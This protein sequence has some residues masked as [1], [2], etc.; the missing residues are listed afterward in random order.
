[1]AGRIPQHFIDELIARADIVE[2]VGA[3][4]PL[5][6]GGREYKGLCPFHNENTPSFTVSPDKGFYHCFGCGAHGTALGFLMDHDHLGF[7]EAV[8][9][10]ASMVGMEV[11]RD[12]G[13][14]KLRG[15]DRVIELLRR[16]AEFYQRCLRD[17]TTAADY[18]KSRG[19]D[20]ATARDYGIG[21]AP[22]GWDTLAGEFG[23]DPDTETLLQAGG[24]VIRRD[25]GGYYDRFRDRV[26]FPIRDGRGRVVG[27]GGRVL[28]KGEPKYL[29]SPETVV[30]SKR[31]EL[32]GMYEVRR[33]LRDIP[34][35]IVVEG[36]MDVV[37][38][39]RNGV[40][41]AV[42]T[43]G[44][45]TT[46]EH[47]KR[48]FRMT[49]EVV[50]CFDGDRAGRQAAWRALEVALPEAR[51]GHQ[52]RFAFLPDGEDPDSLVKA[53]G[54]Q[55]LESELD[56]SLSLSEFLVEELS[57]GLDKASLDGRAQLAER[58]RPL[59]AKVPAGVYRELLIERLA[60]EV[61]LAGA[62]LNELMKP[63]KAAQQTT[64]T[65]QRRNRRPPQQLSLIAR[66]IRALLHRPAL[67]D[68]VDPANLADLTRP[69][70]EL[71]LEL[72]EMAQSDP[73]LTPAALLERM[74]PNT[75][76]RHLERLLGSEF[77]EHAELD[78]AAEFDGCIRQLRTEAVEMRI[79]ALRGRGA[80][81]LSETE[82][83]ELLV[84]LPA[85]IQTLR[86][87]AA[88]NEK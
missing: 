5:T 58:A 22:D 10:L 62:K 14:E 55:A 51:D 69:G 9:Q 88:S 72:L 29:N 37:A 13:D 77:I 57:N 45:A 24:L 54:S 39:A 65:T 34:R 35:L 74:R 76:F 8:E 73:Q 75:H 71:L 67:A 78:L 59:L 48:L 60:D 80:A 19:I 70:T 38:L 26:I 84:E 15:S 33:R 6:R 63:A 61:G 18:L 16:V 81:N 52:M 23:S 30:F 17:N 79:A 40:D 28:G 87:A 3:R 32:Y 53:G 20:G 41:N 44:T 83:R 25:D 50:F 64:P 56:A 42:A 2:V 86:A 7:V 11:P 27:F 21:Y 1:M 36:Y 43:L 68:S 12:A 46:D 66:T 4:V 85:L 49:D 31:R 47:L 82:Q